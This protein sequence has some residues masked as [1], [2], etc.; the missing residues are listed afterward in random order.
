MKNI[1][2]YIDKPDELITDLRKE[3]DG[4]TLE[5]NIQLAKACAEYWPIVEQAQK[6]IDEK[7]A[8]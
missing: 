3:P 1:G 8:H 5:E 7:R 4:L 2:Y 6:A